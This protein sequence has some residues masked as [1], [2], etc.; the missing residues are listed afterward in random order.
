MFLEI[1]IIGVSRKVI[2][3]DYLLKVPWIEIY[4]T[5]KKEINFPENEFTV[6]PYSTIITYFYIIG[7]ILKHSYRLSE[8]I[9]L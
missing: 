6:I 4:S 1:K 3:V 8:I 5:L 7:N 9:A 2:H